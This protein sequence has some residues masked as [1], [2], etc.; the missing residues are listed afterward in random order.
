MKRL[1][2]ALC[3]ALLLACLLCVP[4][5]A[6]DTEAF[7]FDNAGLLSE[8]EAAQLNEA[9]KEVSLRYG[10][11]VYIALFEDM[12][13]YGYRYIESFAEEVFEQWTLGLGE[14]RN[15]IILVMSMADRDYD[16]CAHGDIAHTAFTDYGKEVLADE[17]KD[18]FRRDD[19]AGG[20]RDYIS[21]C[22]YMLDRAEKGDPIDIPDY[23][24]PEPRTLQERLTMAVGPGVIVGIIFGFIYCAALKSKMKSAKIAREAERY[25]APR[26][27]WMQ[28]E[29][30]MF[31]HTTVTRQH[32]QRDNDRGS[33]GG[34]S[35]NSGGFS[36]SSGKF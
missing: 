33:H 29:D 31:T 17:F 22:A 1:F 19:W 3:A 28:A 20:F 12:A 11:G 26:G 7:V 21:Q 2:C 23:P 5:F 32:I 24:E 8:E 34:T 9:A 18:N 4:A 6:E 16:L 27:V 36:H 35:I 30:D 15:A 25:I 13:E 14:E 10:C